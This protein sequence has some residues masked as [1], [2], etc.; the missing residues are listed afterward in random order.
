MSATGSG[1]GERR[2]RGGRESWT[3]RSASRGVDAQPATRCLLVVACPARFGASLLPAHTA[4]LTSRRPPSWSPL[5]LVPPQPRRRML[6]NARHRGAGQGRHRIFRVPHCRPRHCQQ[7][8][9]QL[10][11]HLQVSRSTGM[12]RPPRLR[13]PLWGLHGSVA[14]SA[15][16]PSR[17]DFHGTA[18]PPIHAHARSHPSRCRPLPS[19]FPPAATLSSRP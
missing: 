7:R 6:R 16:A 1:E 15:L 14:T 13:V 3:A 5:L 8:C 12:P 17:I 18:H 2:P 10:L 11:H 19:P 4:Q 9:A